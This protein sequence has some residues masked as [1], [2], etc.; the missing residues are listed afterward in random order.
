MPLVTVY[1]VVEAMSFSRL[2]ATLY[3]SCS[4]FFN[5]KLHTIL[6]SLVH[7]YWQ[8]FDPLSFIRAV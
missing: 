2:S 4:V 8:G 5:L 7:C 6:G 3:S 1:F